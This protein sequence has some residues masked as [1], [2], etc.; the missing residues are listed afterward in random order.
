MALIKTVES[1]FGVD[2][3]YWKIVSY[4]VYLNL[5][6]IDVILAGYASKETRDWKKH[7]LMSD[8]IILKDYKFFSIEDLYKK[9]KES[10]SDAE[11]G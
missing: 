8:K 10:W 5:D 3:T 1:D 6:V 4:Q 9:V 7:P 2:A 11:D